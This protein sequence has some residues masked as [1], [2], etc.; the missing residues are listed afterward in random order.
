MLATYTCNP[1]TDPNHRPKGFVFVRVCMCVCMYV[2]VCM[3]VFFCAR[4]VVVCVYALCV[5]VVC[6]VVRG[7]V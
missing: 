3:C 7:V 5:R 1:D 4:A 6:C 2:R